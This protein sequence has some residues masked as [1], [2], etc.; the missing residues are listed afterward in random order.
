MAASRLSYLR[1]PTDVFYPTVLSRLEFFIAPRCNIYKLYRWAQQNGCNSVSNKH[2]STLT[3]YTV[4]GTKMAAPAPR[5]TAP[6]SLISPSR[7]SVRPCIS[8]PQNFEHLKDLQDKVRMLCAYNAYILYVSVTWSDVVNVRNSEVAAT[9]SIILCLQIMQ[10]RIRYDMWL[11]NNGTALPD[12][13]F[14]RWTSQEM[15][16]HTYE[17]IHTY[18]HPH[19]HT[20]VSL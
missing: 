18:I 11:L 2:A 1:P 8:P 12:Y 9:L 13:D 3:W 20:H 7:P 6:L 15:Y 14:G 19:T 16:I 4:H 5:R 10:G 17:Y